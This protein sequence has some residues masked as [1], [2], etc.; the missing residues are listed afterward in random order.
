[1]VGD[2]GMAGAGMVGMA[3]EL[4]KSLACSHEDL[5]SILSHG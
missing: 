2:S 4:V 1:M 5:G 3:G